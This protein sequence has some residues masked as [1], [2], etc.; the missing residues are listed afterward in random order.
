MN[1]KEI[2]K[3]VAEYVKRHGLMAAGN[4]V[5]VTLSGGADSVALLHI[6]CALR[7]DCIA[8]HC[9]FG[10]R[11]EESDRDEIFVRNLCAR[12]GIPLKVKRFDVKTYQNEHKVS[13]EMACR[14]LRYAWFEEERVAESADF[15]AVAHHHD[16]NV[17]TLFLNLLRGTGIQGLA[18]I[19]PRNGAVVRP[20]L[21]LSRAEIEVYLAA[22]G[23]DFVV[24]STNLESDYKRNKIRNV[25]LPVIRD[26]FPN[27]D[28]AIAR[29]LHNL[30][31][32][33][34]LYQEAVKNIRQKIV[35]RDE[36][37]ITRLS[38]S[39]LMNMDEERETAI[40]EVMKDFGFNSTDTAEINAVVGRTESVGNRYL[41][42]THEAVIGRDYI[43]IF[44]IKNDNKC[45][46]TKVDL[47]EILHT[48]EPQYPFKVQMSDYP[49]AIKPDG[50]NCIILSADILQKSPVLTLRYW[51]KGDRIR[52]FGMR[53]SK[54]VSDLLCDAK[55][56]EYYKRNTQVLVDVDGEVI[57]VI[58]LR[59][60]GKYKVDTE[61]EICVC[62]EYNDKC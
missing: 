60:S 33:N 42:S 18:G 47:G 3:K 28:T 43:D 51:K 56:S 10:L 21:C 4:R 25:L 49:P 6:L 26:L 7:M 23:Q 38:I 55:C 39:A 1:T 22:L 36:A 13:L 44:L 8:L 20:L 17:E 57:W 14:E 5:M 9:N 59:A 46:E 11:G 2:E 48:G 12:L 52:P 35:T 40:F 24:D 34:E 27:A 19:K 61:D 41:S 16:D 50:K 62:L 54:L 37:A 30:Q 53:G 45:G 58:G 32:C 31:G 15:I 29:T